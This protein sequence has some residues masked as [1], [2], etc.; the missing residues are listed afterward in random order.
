M[1]NNVYK[2]PWESLRKAVVADDTDLTT[3]EYNNATYLDRMYVLPLSGNSIAI[4]LWGKTAE[5]YTAAYKL[6]GRRRT[7]GP[8]ESI[9]AGIITLGSRL[10]TKDPLTFATVT[11]YWVDTITDTGNGWISPVVIQNSANNETCYF[12]LNI[13]G[14]NDIELYIDLD[15]G[16]GTAMTELNAIITGATE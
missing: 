5:N 16:G 11:G 1:S 15:G 6:R 3:Y 10:I 8:I 12:C 14:L 4:A 7:N 9:A 2:M 13:F